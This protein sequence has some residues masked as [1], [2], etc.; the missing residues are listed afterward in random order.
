[1]RFVHE[2]LLIQ[3]TIFLI[4]Q[5]IWGFL[6]IYGIIRFKNFDIFRFQ[7]KLS[8]DEEMFETLVESE[9]IK[10]SSKNSLGFYILK[11]W[12]HFFSFL[13]QNLQQF[14][15]CC[16]NDESSKV[17]KIEVLYPPTNIKC[18]RVSFISRLNNLQFLKQL[19][20]SVDF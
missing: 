18:L 16:E 13:N 10:I 14:E 7:I 15:D 8:N 3:S 17:K 5:K 12:V 9:D 1:M 20:L 4:K 6:F 19:N 11:F 2:F